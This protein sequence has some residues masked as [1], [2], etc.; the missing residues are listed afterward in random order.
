MSELYK[1]C[2]ICGEIKPL[3]EFVK[4]KKY[5]DGYRCQC[6]ACAYAAQRAS[7]Q[8]KI[9]VI[10]KRCPLCQEMRK[11]DHFQTGHDVCYTCEMGWN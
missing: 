11:I 8:R 4:D 2:N 3:N 7:K 9:A 1:K 10:G 5:K 6:K